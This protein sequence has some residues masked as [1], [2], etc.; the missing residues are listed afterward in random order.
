[1]RDRNMLYYLKNIQ[2]SCGKAFVEDPTIYTLLGAIRD[3]NN[4]VTVRALSDKLGVSTSTLMRCKNGR[5]PR[6]LK[7]HAMQSVLDRCRD[8]FFCGD[9]EALADS[10]ISYYRQQGVSEDAIRAL[11]RTIEDDGYDEFVAVLLSQAMARRNGHAPEEVMVTED[12]TVATIDSVEPAVSSEI[13]T[14]VEAATDANAAAVESVTPVA[15]MD[16]RYRDLLF[17]LPLAVVL[18]MGLLGFSLADFYLWARENLGG[19]FAIAL[20]TALAPALCGL[21]V[22][23]PLA[24]RAYKKS[25]PDAVLSA[26]AFARVAKYGDPEVL[27]PGAGRFNLTAI[28]LFFQPM[29]NVLSMMT[30]IA[31]FC[32]LGEL[33]E[34]SSF[35][36]RNEW[37]ELLKLAFVTA[38]FLSYGH[39][40][41]QW[42]A[43][44]PDPAQNPLQENPD[45]FLPTRL[46]VWANTMHMVWTIALLSI[47]LMGYL[48]YS[49]VYAHT[50]VM[51]NLVLWPYLQSMAF[52]AHT[53]AS[54]FA[55][56]LRT[57]SVG[58]LL[59]SVVAVSAVF[60]IPAMVCYNPSPIGV[61][62]CVCGVVF[63][64][65]ALTWMRM[66]SHE[67]NPVHEWFEAGRSFW[68]YAAA[69]TC[70]VLVL[71]LV[72][73]LTSAFL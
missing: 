16:V 5:W 51:P 34:F 25:H 36:L 14:A 3:F 62:L 73:F 46:H 48:A 35:F 65:L 32:F 4:E 56:R 21:L 20:S 26:R 6:S 66:H 53:C 37:I 52:F 43:P 40:R 33:P 31:M 7:P 9:G 50:H 57:V 29:C 64:G 15:N 58:M 22:D 39:M 42:R 59:P 44:R 27:I 8:R 55:P 12:S 54:P 38:F 49:V 23:S 68:A 19:F 71:V 69:M 18:L 10:I 28:Y 61:V 2:T 30:Y 45:T 70:T 41:E 47:M 67:E 72:G 11:E 1:M 13:T 63:T 24:W 60:A 17:A